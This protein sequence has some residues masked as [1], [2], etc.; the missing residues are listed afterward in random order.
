MT[1]VEIFTRP[2]TITPLGVERCVRKVEA[3]FA[4]HYPDAPALM[5][6]LREDF[7]RNPVGP[8]V[9]VRCD[10]WQRDGK[11]VLLGDAAH[12]VVPFYGQG[13]NASFEDCEA[14]FNAIEHHPGDL[15]TACREYESQRVRHAN[16]IADLALANFI[17]MR[18][19][20]GRW[21]FRAKPRPSRSSRRFAR[22]PGAGRR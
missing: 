20:T 10:P 11:V 3:F 2:T 14:L 18:D 15:E 9:T 12:A 6:T 4:R 22:S 7:E 17:E 21:W 16:A 8:L 5:P 1:I 19:H 13:A